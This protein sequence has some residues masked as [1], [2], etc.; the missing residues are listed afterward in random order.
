MGRRGG[1]TLDAGRAGGGQRRPW[2]KEMRTL[3]GWSGEG[4]GKLRVCH[5]FLAL[6]TVTGWIWHDAHIF[7]CYIG[8][9]FY[10]LT[11]PQFPLGTHI[12]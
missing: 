7:L 2:E 8:S 1:S 9:V 12:P 6:R 4:V 11:E 3:A 10:L 5:Q